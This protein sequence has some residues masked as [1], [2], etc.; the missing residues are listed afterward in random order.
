MKTLAYLSVRCLVGTFR[1]IP[2]WLLYLLSDLLRLVLQY[3][4]RYRHEVIR[5][6]LHNAFPTKNGHEIKKITKH[7]Y[8]NLADVILESIKGLS[9]REQELRNRYSYRNSFIFNELYQN[10]KNAILLG[11]HIAN[12]EWGVLSFPLWVEQ[13]V[14]G[15]YKPLSNPLTDAFLNKLRC[16]WGLHLYSMTNIGRAVVRQ[17][18]SPAIFVLIAD[19]TPSDIGNAHWLD[20]L[21]QPTAF[22]HGPGKLAEKTGFSV[23]SFAIQRF[24]RGF[25]EVSFKKLADETEALS[26]GEITQRYAA[27][28]ERLICQ[29]PSDWLWSHRRWKHQ[30]PTKQPPIA[31]PAQ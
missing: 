6:N 27:E 10:K 3:M 11:S 9:L 23:Y 12:W 17:R 4:V 5:Q 30:P 1:F 2:F 24:R 31:S 21:N 22:L 28:L 18:Q 16:R 7:Y 20:F 14:V 29:K 8:R 15:I 26:A 25:Y 19:Q 13:Q